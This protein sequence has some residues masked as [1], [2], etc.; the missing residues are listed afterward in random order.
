VKTKLQLLLPIKTVPERWRLLE[1]QNQAAALA[2]DEGDINLAL[3]RVGQAVAVV[4]S[5]P[6]RGRSR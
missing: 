4:L 5:L 2:I 1:L 3:F 6:L